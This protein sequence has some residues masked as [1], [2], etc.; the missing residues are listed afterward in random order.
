MK[1][2][3]WI[4]CVLGIS[5]V[6]VSTVVISAPEK[7]E[8][9]ESP[10][11]S[12]PVLYS[13][14][15]SASSDQQKFINSLVS[16]AQAD[17]RQ[18]KLFSSITLAQAILESGWGKSDLATK[19][20]N[21]FGIKGSYNGQSYLVPTLEYI[22]GQWVTINANFR[23]YPSWSASVH[24]HTML[25]V[26]GTS[27]DPAHYSKV[28]NA[29]TYQEAANELQKAGYATDPN[30]PA[31]L[32]NIIETYDLD[33]YDKLY[34][35]ISNERVY[36]GYATIKTTDGHAVWT[37]PYGTENA[38]FVN[39]LSAYSGKKLELNRVATTNRAT[40]Y[41]FAI[42]G[43][44][45]GWVDSRALNIFYNNGMEVA[46]SGT[47]YVKNTS[48]SYYKYP[49]VDNPMRLGSLSGYSGKKLT[50]DRKATILGENWV[51]VFS[52]GTKLGWVKEND[53]TTSAPI[54]LDYDKVVYAYGNVSNS[55]NNGIW[56]KPYGLSGATYVG[57]VSNYQG[58]KI[59]LLRQA[60]TSDGV[61]WYEF[62]ANGK[63]IGWLDSRAITVFY[64]NSMEQNTSGTRY[65][66][67]TSGTYNLYPVVDGPM[68]LGSLSGYA[69]K[70]LT[71]DRKA[72]ILG[73][74]WVRV[75]YNGTK[76][77][78]VKEADLSTTKQITL[79]YDKVV[80]AYGNVSNSGNN[81]IWTK[82]YG[83]SGATYVGPVS[84]YQGQKIRLL[85]QAK[86]SDG[87]TWYEFSA[88]GKTIGWL[89][90]RAIT[91]FY[92]NS[93]EQNTSG[94]RY[95]KNTSGTYNL[96]PVVDGPMTLGSLS[97]YAGK[98]LTIDRKATI[99][100]ENWVRVFYN[101]TKLG[102]VK[103]ADLSTTKQITLDYD[104]VVY[105][106]GNVSNSGNNGIW[107]KPYG[108]SGATYVGPVSNYQGQKIRLLRQAKTSDGVTWYE[109]SANGK[110]IGWL[111]ARAISV[112]YDSSME[113][114]TSGTRYVKNVNGTYNL[115]PVVDGP[116]ILGSLS[117]Y[118][119]KA[120]TIDRKATIL[121]ENWVRTVYNGTRLGWVKENDLKLTK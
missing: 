42:D 78:W 96:Y 114:N 59:R 86:T 89:D 106:Y 13:S 84:N 80:Y 1:R 46:T 83:L 79:D 71:I 97:G 8:A 62:S 39:D 10:L 117:T 3:K 101:G 25:L 82:P 112:F 72:T 60:K 64:D 51:R 109:F 102:W 6:L 18:Y 40:W 100:G 120:L 20:N 12:V 65:V 74:N 52:N 87:V 116:M 15:L 2:R 17:Q 55:G 28:V 11:A 30:Y 107:T 68:T 31:K 110:T 88:N 118:T 67:N 57:P 70:A 93:M 36:Y 113:Q 27:W 44:T 29:K 37:R 105:A 104:K 115:Y 50:I 61:T 99:L 43:K 41:Q 63:T 53:L 98:A 19:A 69:G 4:Q 91:V 103:E 34:D 119:G 45:I 24:D 54:T 75:F 73:E 56:T 32:I 16:Q 21:L 5:G 49:V 48:G 90:S 95:V 58:Q 23:K 33:Q 81:G 92:D 76:L 47:R 26:N 108:L 111:D 14:A 9:A 35:V 94:T 22:N 7:T 77:G 66:K 38:Q 121:G 85:R